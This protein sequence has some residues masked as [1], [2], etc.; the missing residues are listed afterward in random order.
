MFFPRGLA[1][2]D[3]GNLAV[4]ET[5]LAMNVTDIFNYFNREAEATRTEY[6]IGGALGGVYKIL[7]WMSVALGVRYIYYMGN[8]DIKVNDLVYVVNDTL[9]NDIDNYWN[10]NTD[11]T[12]HGASITL[13]FHFR[14]V[15]KLD[16]GFKY[17]YF[18]PVEMTKKTNHFRIN[19]LIEQ[20]GSLNIFK[21]GSPGKEMTYAGGNGSSTFTMQYPMRFNLGISYAILKSL[22]AEING[23]LSLVRNRDMDGRENDYKDVG[24]R[25]GACLEWWFM[26]NVC[27]SAGYSFN[28]FGIKENQ[29]NEADHL[30]PS[31][32]IGAGLGFIIT[33]RFDINIGASYEY[34][35][36]KETYTS[37][38]TH[39]TDPTYHYLHKTFD[40][41]RISVALGLTYRFLGSSGRSNESDKKLKMDLKGRES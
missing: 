36:S 27:I 21:D 15:E 35:I 9:E 29:R 19:P 23:E 13:G 22:R 6:F 28:D 41:Y 24:Y 39:V 12:G 32:T 11:Y 26:K 3:W 30:L 2:M 8:M 40:E 17:V 7:E 34:F 20:S 18:T 31:H 10:I 5:Q 25:L 1:V 4:R 33:D 16:M 14:L 38:F 37:E